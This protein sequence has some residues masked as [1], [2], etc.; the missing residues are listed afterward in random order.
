MHLFSCFAF[1]ITKQH[2]QRVPNKMSI[3]FKHTFAN[4]LTSNIFYVFLFTSN[5]NIHQYTTNTRTTLCKTND[6]KEIPRELYS[7]LFLQPL[8]KRPEQK[9]VYRCQCYPGMNHREGYS[10]N[11]I[12]FE[13]LCSSFFC[14]WPFLLNC[15]WDEHTEVTTLQT[16][17]LP[18]L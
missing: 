17:F 15:K 3:K 7:I 5:Q 12:V 18:S 11:E 14:L 13:V 10:S 1:D 4:I 9:T 2:T 16:Y 6:K 8:T